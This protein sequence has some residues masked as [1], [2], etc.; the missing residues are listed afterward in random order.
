MNSRLLKFQ[1]CFKKKKKK[2]ASANGSVK[3]CVCSAK[4]KNGFDTEIK[5]AIVTRHCLTGTRD[6]GVEERK[7]RKEGRES[8]FQPLS[9]GVT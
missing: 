2:T 3:V 8:F 7:G 9:E 1:L 4:R 5:L 6:E